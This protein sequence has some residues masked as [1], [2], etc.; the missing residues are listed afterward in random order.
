MTPQDLAALPPARG[1]EAAP[2]GIHTIGEGC[3]LHP[4]IILLHPDRLKLGHH[5]RIDA[6][7]KLECGGVVILGNYVHLASFV[8]FI[9]NGPIVMGDGSGCSSGVKIISGTAVPSPIGCSAMTPNVPTLA[10]AVVVGARAT[11]FA[12][13]I[14]LPGCTIGEGAVVA[15]GSV[16]LADTNIPAYQLWAGVPAVFKKELPQ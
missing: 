10:R 1:S 4:P 7:T 15:A 6:F 9:G 5:V 13:A 3:L 16:V 14:L 12:G 2:Y 8:H 11:V